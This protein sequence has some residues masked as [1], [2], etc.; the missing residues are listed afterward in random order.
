[1]HQHIFDP[2]MKVLQAEISR[3]FWISEE[4]KEICPPKWKMKQEDVL[5]NT[6]GSVSLSY[7]HWWWYQGWGRC[8]QSCS[9]SGAH[10]WGVWGG[11]FPP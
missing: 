2:Q 11:F 5:I 1:M 8:L 10:S 6:R 4:L 7:R 3:L 9:N